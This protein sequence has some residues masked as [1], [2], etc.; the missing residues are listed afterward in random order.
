[1]IEAA[2]AWLGVVSALCL[3]CNTILKSIKFYYEDKDK[4]RLERF[5]RQLQ[6]DS[7]IDPESVLGNIVMFTETKSYPY[8][9]GE[10]VIDELKKNKL[11]TSERR[12][13]IM[14]GADKK[15]GLD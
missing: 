11:I 8:Q 6:L 7:S 5:D 10:A 3:V 13:Y 12:N 2:I 4:A 15:K 1:M 9:I 14:I